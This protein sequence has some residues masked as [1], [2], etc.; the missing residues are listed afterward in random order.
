[1]P[2]SKMH[3]YARMKC[4]FCSWRTTAAEQ[5]GIHLVDKHPDKVIKGY[6]KIKTKQPSRKVK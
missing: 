6:L 2:R 3:L 4:P 1:M 5:L